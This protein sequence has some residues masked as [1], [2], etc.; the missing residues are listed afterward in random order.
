[1]TYALAPRFGPAYGPPERALRPPM[2]ENPSK[3][4]V[5]V[6]TTDRDRRRGGAGWLWGILGLVMIALV[7][8][9][10]WPEDEEVFTDADV[11]AELEPVPAPTTGEPGEVT[12][13]MILDNPAE[14]V[15][16]E[17]PLGEVRVAEVPSDRG[18]WIE[19]DGRRLFAILIDQPQEEPKDIQAGQSLRL[20]GGTLRDA[21]YLGQIEGAPLDEETRGI[22]EAQQVFLVVDEDDIVMLDVQAAQTGA[23]PLQTE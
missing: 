12:L 1:M 10:V 16:H 11:A 21:S 19:S 14:H 7:V 15:G 13:A 6:D 23:D 20:E 3:E 5:M 8:W 2:A 18:F 9:L 4:E 22:V 17:L